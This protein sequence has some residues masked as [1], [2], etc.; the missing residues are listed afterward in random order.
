V[1]QKSTDSTAETV[2]HF[3]EFCKGI[4][5]DVLIPR[6]KGTNEGSKRANLVG[7]P[8]KRYAK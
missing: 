8:H 7:F 4:K 6:Q 1:E 3:D 2:I 5:D